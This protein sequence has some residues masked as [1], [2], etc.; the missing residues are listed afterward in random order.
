MKLS[1]NLWLSEVTK[2]NTA[3]RLGIKNN[4]TKQHLEN[5][6][7]L[8]EKVFQ[9]MR[10]EANSP[11]YVSSGYR[12]K[13]LNKA[14]GGSKR[15][16]H[17]FGCALDLDNDNKNDEFTNTHIFN[18]IRDNLEFTQLIWEFGDDEKPAWVHVSLVPGREN[19]K[20]VLKAVS[21]KSKTKYI[22]M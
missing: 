16:H 1:K 8:A 15:S 19:E 18:Y 12:S 21:V 17:C 5:L 20:T 7:N 14:V 11:I 13:K 10:D 3:K 22:K 2:S 4:P 9:P 6:K